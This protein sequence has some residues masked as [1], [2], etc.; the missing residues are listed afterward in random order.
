MTFLS[1]LLTILLAYIGTTLL[2]FGAAHLTSSQRSAPSS[3]Q[4]SSQPHQILSFSARILA[5]VG[6]LCFCATYGALASIF[7]RLA[8]Y[9]GLGQWACARSFKYTMWLVTG[10]WFDIVN[11][12]QGWAFGEGEG[13]KQGSEGGAWLKTR[14]AVFMGNHQTE[15]DILVL[16]TMFPKYCSVTAKKS[17]R[18]VPFLG[19]F[20]TLFLTHFELWPLGRKLCAEC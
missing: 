3:K 6:A 1:W 16:G 4:V 10:V 8:G 11:E 15:L 12:G 19:Q 14:P 2:L 17:L 20:S 9:G 18:W 13:G 5:S 7:V